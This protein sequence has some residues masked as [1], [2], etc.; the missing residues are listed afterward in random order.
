MI[1]QILNKLKSDERLCELLKPTPTD[2][3]IHMFGTS[4]GVAYKWV[5]LTDDGVKQQHRL[6]ITVIDKSY[7]KC[8][9]ISKR[10]QDILLTV[11]DK[12]FNNDILTIEQNGGGVLQQEDTGYIYVK[13]YFTIKTRRIE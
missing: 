8:T 10:I 7:G 3:K 4:E 12:T 9:L 6:E 11:G 2:S 5:T 1:L 13:S